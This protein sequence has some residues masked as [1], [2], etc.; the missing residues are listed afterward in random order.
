MGKPAVSINLTLDQRAEL[1]GLVRRRQT[2][3]GLAR[4]AEIVL[5]AADGLQNKEIVARLGKDANTVGKWRRRFAEF[6]LDGLYDAER[7]DSSAFSVQVRHERSVMTILPRRSGRRLRR[8]RLMRP[9]GPKMEVHGRSMAKVTGYAPSTIHRIWQAFGL[10]PHR[11]ETFKLSTDPLKTKL[12]QP[13]V[14]E[15]VRDIV[16]LY[17]DPPE[18]ALVLFGVASIGREGDRFS[19]CRDLRRG[20]DQG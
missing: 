3:Q 5:L 2:A 7:C 12:P 1:E 4:R 11:S 6:G 18:R 13:S 9:I 19:P 10:Q 17:L 20:A 8:H 15:K 14:V 16:G